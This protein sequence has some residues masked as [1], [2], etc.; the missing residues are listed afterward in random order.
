MSALPLL[1]TLRELEIAVHQPKVWSDPA[2]LDELLHPAFHEF[3]RS[4]ASDTRAEVLAEFAG[5]EQT[6][7]VWFQDIV[8]EQVGEGLALLTHRSAHVNASGQLE[9]HT[10]RSSLWQLTEGGWKM[11]FHQGTPTEAFSRNET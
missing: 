7:T 11:R 1:E 5:H 9:R 2:G 10:N 4:G 6:Y 8:V 3:G